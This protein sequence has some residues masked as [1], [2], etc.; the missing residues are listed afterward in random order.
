[1][2]SSIQHIEKLVD[3]NYEAWKMQ[4]RSVLIYN[5]LWGYTS[6]EIVQSTTEAGASNWT[7]KDEKALAL[8]VL[9]VSK[10]ELGHIRKATTSKQAWD[11]L[12]RIHSSKG[13]VRKAVLYRQLYNLKK[14][15][16]ETMSQYINNFQEKVNLLEDAEIQIPP[17]L[18][19][20]MLLSNLPEEYDNFCV[21]IESRDQIP[22]VDLI[23]GK[24]I[25]EEARRLGNNNKEDN[26]T[27]A[28][29]SRKAHTSRG[30]SN[31]THKGSTKGDQEMKKFE[32]NCFNCGKYGHPANRCRL[33]RKNTGKVNQARNT[34]EHEGEDS[35]IAISALAC[36]TDK[37][38]WYLDSGATA[39]MCND[40]KAFETLSNGPISNISTAGKENIIS[41]GMGIVRINVKVHGK[42]KS[43]KLTN[44]L[45]VPELRSNLLSVPAITE[46]KYKVK[47]SDNNAYVNKLDNSLVFTAVKRN[48]MYVVKQ[49]NNH[50]V[51]SAMSDSDLKLKLWHERY[52]HLNYKDLIELCDKKRVYGIDL[53][54]KKQKLPCETCDQAKI[55]TL[56]FT[57]GTRAKNVLE[58]VHTDIC[59]PMNIKSYGNARYFATFIDDKTRYME[60]VFL[61]SRSDI[62]KEFDK[63][64]LRVERETGRKIVKLRS[65]NAK[66]YISKEFNDY[67]EKLGVKRQLTVEYTPQQN[68]VAERANRT[69]VEMARAMLI[70]S[71]VPKGLWAEAVNT[72]AFLRNRCPSKANNGITPHESWSNRKPNVKFIKV[73][74]SHATY[75]KKGAGI[76]KFDPKGEKAIFVG[77]SSESKAYR[78][79]LPGT[80][81]IIK[82]RDVRFIENIDD[83][84]VESIDV[85]LLPNISTSNETDNEKS[86]VEKEISES[87]NDIEITD[88]SEYE[89]A[90][91][92]LNIIETTPINERRTRGRPK[93][94]KTGNPGRPKKQYHTANVAINSLDNNPDTIED[95]LKRPDKEEWLDAMNNEY[96]SLLECNTWDLVDRTSDMK[97]IS[98]KWVFHIKRFQSG[99][100]NKYKARLVARG[101]EQK[102]GVDYL[103]V[104]APVARIQ[105]IRTLLAISA[106]MSYYVHQMDVTTAYI[107]G[108]LSETI[109]MEQP[110]LFGNNKNKVCRLRRPI[111][112]LKQSGRAWQQK[113]SEKLK[114]I[115][116]SAS[117]VEPCVYTGNID[118]YNVIIVVYVD[119]LLVASKS[120]EVLQKVKLEL[121]KIFKMKD[122]GPVNEILGIQIERDGDK[123]SIK[124]SQ[125]KYI[126][127]IIERFGMDSCKTAYT[128]L[129][130]GIKLSKEMEPKNTDEIK[131]MENKPYKELIGCLNY[132]ANTTRPDISFTVG[133]LSRYNLN[134]GIQ[135]WKCAKHVIRYL[136]Q[137]A[138]YKILYRKTEKPLYAY[139]DAD[140]AGDQD[141]RKSC[142]GSVHILA[143]GPISW[144]SKKQTTIALS[145]MEAEYVALSESTKEVIHLRRLIKE[146]YGDR[147]VH[148]ATD[149]LCDN[150]SAIVLSKENMLHQRSKHIE[151]KHHFTRD[152]QNKGLINV[153]F[154]PTDKNVAD[155]LTKALVKDKQ[156]SC[157][158]LLNLVFH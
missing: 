136:K 60:I 79:W 111:Y 140:W 45:Y 71:N 54:L 38:E 156:L 24:L 63:Y 105:T 138:D 147:Y 76:K 62:L 137:T 117:K 48:H 146:M 11:E 65:D 52:G 158:R 17:E 81:K 88:S 40:R 114:E 112:G 43:I 72:A 84:N 153:K 49:V 91:D 150:Q 67:V 57:E 22:S 87:E 15:P 116:L 108:D 109:Y 33:K 12:A 123:G 28:L 95:I 139:T 74:G 3:E 142:S 21:A 51:F 85:D 41:H 152:A 93:M 2:N 30:S 120:L 77:Y 23:K 7:N 97:V 134:P 133:A 99:E 125:K 69:I 121:N 34:K 19:S 107:Q 78:L 157:V 55:H 145:T 50:E 124:I 106:E 101:C 135:H 5:D 14:N 4:M 127:E 13:P 1:M 110:L 119:D 132:L 35:L 131:L 141:E 130:S 29:V 6:G 25:E 83:N 128:P 104:Y 86:I 66:E 148:D 118:N 98:S 59:G 103:E 100:I 75:L 27:S 102:Y 122:L 37:N 16:S 144:F 56:P 18:Q 31:Y 129:A 20:I 80:T 151:I 90:S 8:I 92:T 82:S 58:L 61:K 68:G 96:K 154:V 36:W 10:P 47:F 42:I 126:N 26:S 39:H 155:I 64:R 89:E 149:I 9:S 46:K 113:L 115:G 32:G 53:P 70:K 44:V 94:I 143:G 73:F